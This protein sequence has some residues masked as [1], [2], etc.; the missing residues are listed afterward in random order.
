MLTGLWLLRREGSPGGERG[1]QGE[2][3]R[4]AA[5]LEVQHHH[6]LAVPRRQRSPFPGGATDRERGGK[7]HRG[8]MGE[9]RGRDSRLPIILH[10]LLI[11]ATSTE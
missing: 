2:R 3:G 4:E 8:E 11:A 6:L 9:T 5:A 1:V 7:G 10:N